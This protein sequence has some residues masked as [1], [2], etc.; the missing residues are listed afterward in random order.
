VTWWSSE[1]CDL[2]LTS[3]V[4]EANGEWQERKSNGEANERKTREDQAK[5]NKDETSTKEKC[6]RF[7]H[8]S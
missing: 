3:G 1:F 4:V 7:E 2:F 5:S 6:M 8:F